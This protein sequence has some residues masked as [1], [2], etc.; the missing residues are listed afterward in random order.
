MFRAKT[1]LVIGAGASVEVDLPMG[2]DLLKQIVQLLQIRF[3]HFQQSA[4]DPTILEAIKI[5]VN[6]GNKVEKANQH[7]AAARQLGESAKQALSIDNVIDALE[8]PQVE[9][10]GKL[11]IVRAILKAEALSP[12]FKYVE[13][14]PDRINLSKFDNTWYSS[15]TKLLTENVRKSKVESIFD[16]LSIVNFNY[17][18]C[19]EH[20][21]PISL[22]SYYGLNPDCI[23]ETMHGL[24]MHR[25]YGVAGRLPWQKGSAPSVSFGGGSPQQIADVAQQVR[26]FTE[27]VEEGDELAAMR[28]TIA[29]ADRVVFLGF[30]FHRQNVELLASRMMDHSEILA[31]SY[32]ISASDK[33]VIEEELEVAFGH[34]QVLNDTRVQLADM[35]CDQFFREYWRTLTADKGSYE[36]LRM[37]EPTPRMP[38]IG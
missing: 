18:R 11:G 33:G 27:R 4:G 7:L 28:A 14:Q 16:N 20:Y 12:K 38:T 3:E 35:K 5:C 31:T 32:N 24:T 1:V 8:D 25:P 17:D 15:L 30:A 26:T 23:R 2:P 21:L 34:E 37:P 29:E 19:L 13:N 10:V 9:L 6:E 22:G 36:P